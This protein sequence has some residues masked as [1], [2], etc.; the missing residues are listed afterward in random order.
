[1]NP[2]RW[3]INI[4]VNTFGIT[5]PSPENEASAGKVIALMLA[6]V[7]LVLGMVAWLLRS[8]FTR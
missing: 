3:L 1:V 2:L 5:R 6:A 4:F 7:A 8:S